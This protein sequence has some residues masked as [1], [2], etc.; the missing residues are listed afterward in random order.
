MPGA[1]AGREQQ[2]NRLLTGP[3]LCQ[4][5]A[6]ADVPVSALEEGQRT[7]HRAVC[8]TSHRHQGRG[9]K[10]V[11]EQTDVR[12]AADE[13]KTWSSASSEPERKGNSSHYKTSLCGFLIAPGARPAPS[14]VSKEADFM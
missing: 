8:G 5:L 2:T 14:A 4:R 7:G 10:G 6:L 12:A 1:R 13:R 11:S 9:R 3:G